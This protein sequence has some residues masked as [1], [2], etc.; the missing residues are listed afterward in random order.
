MNHWLD[1]SEVNTANTVF[2]VVIWRGLCVFVLFKAFFCV[3]YQRIFL[4]R[5]KNSK[6]KYNQYLYLW[7]HILQN[8]VGWINYDR[9]GYNTISSQVTGWKKFKYIGLLFFSYLP[10]NCSKSYF[11]LL[12]VW[13]RLL[14]QAFLYISEASHCPSS[15]RK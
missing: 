6:T 5:P 8:Q 11:S 13:P 12:H 15:Y 7:L 2:L 14:P 1:S 9:K 3:L 10:S 4:T